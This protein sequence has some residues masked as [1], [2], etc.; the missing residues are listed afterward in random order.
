[1]T[2]CIT[3]AG[4][5]NVSGI[6]YQ[7][8]NTK[9]AQL[10]ADKKVPAGCS[11]LATYGI[12]KNG[13][14]LVFVKNLTDEIMVI[15]QEMSF[16]IDS[17]GI[18]TSYYDPTVRTTTNTNFDASTSGSSV[19]LG[20]IASAF[21]VGGPLGTLL[22]GVN[23]SNS[24]TAGSSSSNTITIRDEKKVRIGPRGGV[25]LSKNFKI[26]G[27]GM[28]GEGLPS[29]I[30]YDFKN[31]PIRFSVCIYY[32]VDEGENFEKLV[33]DFYTT[34]YAY[35]PIVKG[36]KVNDTLRQI[37]MEKPDLL[38][39]PWY[40]LYF[41]NNLSSV[42]GDDFFIPMSYHSDVYDNIVHGML[43]DFQ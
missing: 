40:I 31:S 6:G 36:K 18:S 3:T 16:F 7:A 1:M 33:T 10:P 9:R 37:M 42:T 12:D 41:K 14:L 22:G 38:S 11:I 2:G 19:N 4:S 25:A 21:G 43:F 5:L 23:V 30:P 29:T 28:N 24:S 27:I 15:D 13:H 34:T 39:Q 26:T 35:E 20:A 32:S 8:I 17:D